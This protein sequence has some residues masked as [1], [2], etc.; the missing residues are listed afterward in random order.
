MISAS[1]RRRAVLPLLV[2]VVLMVFASAACQTAQDDLRS[3]VNS[4]RSSRGIAALA[5]AGDLNS[6]A[7]SQAAVIAKSGQLTHSNLTA[8]VSS[9]WTRLGEN[10]GYASS[11][12]EAHKALMAS[13]G[14]RANILDGRFKAL[15]IGVV[16]AKNGLYYVVEEFAA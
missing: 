16:Q 10:I 8:G 13:A 3:R 12:A 9:S 15:G 5:S 1:H 2:A 6:K 4:E 7:Q 14:H 11:I